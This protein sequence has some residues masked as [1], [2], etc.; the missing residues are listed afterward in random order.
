MQSLTRRALSRAVRHAL[1]LAAVAPLAL[2]A[3]EPAPATEL[4]RIQ[5]TGSRIS[6]A[7]IEGQTPVQTITRAD[8]ERSGLTSVGDVLQQMTASGSALNTKFNSSG[9]FGFPP[10]GGGVGAGAT[11]VDLRHLG[12]KRVLVLVDGVRWVNES[13]ASGVGGVVD[14]NTIPLGIIDRIEVLED[15]AS[16]IYGSDAIAGVVNIITRRDVDGTSVAI[17][18]GQFGKGDGETGSVDVSF[19]TR[20]E[21]HSFF[22]GASYNEQRQVAS[23]DRAQSSLPV[24]GTGVALGSAAIPRGRFIFTDPGS[25]VTYD[26]VP[27]AGVSNHQFDASQTGCE[28]TDDFSCF[29]NADRFNF[30]EYNLLLTPNTR[31]SVYAQSR[32]DLTDATTWYF[33]A[34]YNNRKS[35]NQAA[36]EPFFLGVAAPTNFWADN[37]VWSASNPFNPFG[38]DLVGGDNFILGG[39]RPLEGGP[40]RFQQDVDTFYV[41]TGFEGRIDLGRSPLFWDVNLAHGTNKATQTNFGSYNAR[42]LAL[43]L[44]DPAA[45]AAEPNCVPVNLIGP[46]ALTPEMLAYIQPVLRDSSENRLTLF[47]ANLSGDLFDLPAGTVAYA[48]GLEHRRYSA[49]YRPDGLTIAGEYNGVPSLPTRGEYDVSEAYVE[50]NV[51]LLADVAFARSLDLSL[52]GRYSDYSTF[53]GE[54]T[55]KAGL[56]WQVSDE[57]LLRGTWAEGF[58][59]PTVG[60][61]FASASGFDKVL[62]DPCSNVSA[63]LAANCAALGVPDGYVQPN[64]QI[65]IQ[66][67]GNT[68]L[69]PEQAESVSAGLVWSPA[70][71]S[72][73]AWSER[74]D[75]EVTWFKH[76]I[77]DAIQARDAEI[78]LNLCVQTL[79]PRFCDGITRNA[80]GAIDGFA[81]QLTNIGRIETRGFDFDVFWTLPET[82]HGRYR[83]SWRTTL[84]DRYFAIDQDG[85]RQS[86]A[87]GVESG[88]AGI[89]KWSS[90]LSVDWDLDNLFASWSVR[91]LSRL[92]EECGDLARPFPVCRDA[93]NNRNWLGST[94]YHD[95]RVGIRTDWLGGSS[96]SLGVN[97]VFQKEPPICLS[98]SLNGY[99]ASLYDIPGGRFWYV[100]AE[101]QF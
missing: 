93:P 85:A 95:A 5:V 50:F 8:I 37:A 16:S 51:P 61:L 12:P 74:L 55:A 38:I 69:N 49:S 65:S 4:D 62:T 11:T 94:T 3:Q 10:D 78:Q 2:H 39:Y 46:N 58:R 22:L 88:D 1:V 68:E 72:G 90:N 92:D 42:R 15:G 77:T 33:R 29:T 67:G 99:D 26:L 81:N 21:R 75:V 52:A 100:R 54:T 48:T 14:L 36:A 30:A 45:C 56:R 43:G 6:K 83:I 76:R 84:V 13:S 41:G 98:C 101:I 63:A 86:G 47:T 87:V 70:F 64:P 18:Y 19:G 17:Q 66:T 27:N 9:N 57:F 44:G 23:R 60:E 34:L 32:F 71:A 89:P 80:L 82:N 53:G 25:G 73:A 31:K 91:H 35:T 59:A 40:R 7:E 28:R 20:G 79:D 96:F 97:N 24:P